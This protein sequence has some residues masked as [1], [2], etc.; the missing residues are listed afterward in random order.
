LS[1]RETLAGIS[2]AVVDII[3]LK[4]VT[5]SINRFADCCPHGFF[6]G[7]RIIIGALDFIVYL[8][9]ISHFL[10]GQIKTNETNTLT[11]YLR[12]L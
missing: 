1:N 5:S 12:P 9:G 3:N 4:L 10:F 7:T 6:L 8:E 11:V 2:I